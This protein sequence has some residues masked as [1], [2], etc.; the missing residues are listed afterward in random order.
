MQCPD[1]TLFLGLSVRVFLEEINTWIGRPSK[2]DYPHQC[3]W[4]VSSNPSRSRIEQKKEDG[5]WSLLSWDTH[6]PLSLGISTHGPLAFRLRLR[7][8]L[9]SPLVLIFLGLD[10][11]YTTGFPGPPAY[12]QQIVKLLSL[13]NHMSQSLIINLFPYICLY[14]V[15]WF[16]HFGERWITQ[17]LLCPCH[18]IEEWDRGGVIFC[19][20]EL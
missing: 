4:V 11:S 3:E 2:K 5:N 6:L 1:K 10:C 13:H 9:L 20:W 16:S 14:I 19:L 7:L 15:Y 18:W 17:A 8:T 12:R